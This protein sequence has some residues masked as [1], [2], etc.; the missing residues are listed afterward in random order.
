MK[1]YRLQHKKGGGPYRNK[2]DSSGLD[3]HLRTHKTPWAMIDE[4][5]DPDAM[6]VEV[7][8]WLKKKGNAFGWDSLSK[9]LAYVSI[10]E[11]WH[12]VFDKGYE[13]LVF[14]C[15]DVYT[16]PDGQTMFNKAASSVINKYHSLHAMQRA[17]NQEA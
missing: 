12:H 17:L 14:D 6:E 8:H 10:T 13:V 5:H 11:D 1:V 2:S 3:W 16:F 15:D 4:A 9:M 7:R